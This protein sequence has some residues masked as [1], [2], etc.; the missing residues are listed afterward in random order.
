MEKSLQSK[1][2]LH[3]DTHKLFNN[4]LKIHQAGRLVDAE[5]LYRQILKAEPNHVDALHALGVLAR[6]TGRPDVAVDLIRKAISLKSDAPLFYNNLGTALQDQKKLE[7]ALAQYDHAIA[8]RPDY[9]GAYV[10]I[11]NVYTEQGRLDDAIE[12]YRRAISLNAKFAE[13]Y[14]SLGAALKA[15]NKLDEALI[16]YKQALAIRP[17]YLEACLNIGNVLKE[18]WKLDDAAKYYERAISLSP[19]FAEAHNGLGTVLMA[20]GRLSDAVASYE[21]ALALKPNYA[22]A[23]SNLG[24]ALADQGNLEAA[25][26]QGRLAMGLNSNDADAHY[27]YSITCLVSGNFEEGWR[28]FEW[29]WKRKDVPQHRYNKPLWDG[30]PLNGKTLLLH[31]EQGLGDSIQFIRYA[32]MIDKNGGR[33]VMACPIALMRLF[34][35][36]DGIDGIFPAKQAPPDYDFQA[37]LMSLP[38]LMKTRLETIP[39]SVPYLCAEQE[40]AAAWK[41]RLKDFPG[42]KI[43]VVWRGNPNHKND[44]NRSM[45]PADF[46]AFLEIEGISVVN[47]QKDARD[48]EITALNIMGPFLD[49]APDLQDFADTAALIANLDLVISVDTSVCHLAGALGIPVWTL[50]PHAPDWRWLMTREDSPWYPSMRL[51][52]Q[53]K[54]GDWRSVVKKLGIEIE[55]L[56]HGDRKALLP[57]LPPPQAIPETNRRR[58]TIESHQT[59]VERWSDEKQLEKSWDA[60]AQRAADYVPACA[61]VLDLGCGRMAFEKFLPKDCRYMPCDVARRDERTILCDFNKGEYP[62]AEAGTADIISFLGVMEYIFDARTFLSRLRQWQRPVVMSYCTTEGIRDRNQRRSLG[63]V[64]DFSY[65]ELVR[66]LE[67]TGFSIQ[68]ADRIDSVQ[69]LFRLKPDRAA[70]P[71]IKRVAILSYYN[72]GNFGDRLG[73]H[74]I[75]DILPAHAEA[76]NLTFKPWAPSSETYDLLIL[77]MGNSLFGPMVNDSLLSLV[78]RSRSTIGIFGTQYHEAMPRTMLN[79]LLGRLD[80]WYARYEDDILRYGRSLNNASHLGDWLIK[81]FPMARPVTTERLDIGEEI[82]KELPLDR[83]I[84]NI[85]RHATVFSTRLH[86]LLCALTSA[87]RVGYREQREMKGLTSGKFRSLLL[88]VFGRTFPEE[89]LWAVD[90]AQVLTYKTAIETRVADLRSHIHRILNN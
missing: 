10:N 76:T 4:A 41:R 11:G 79:S 48:N 36:I 7:E 86:P 47:L 16:Q 26:E 69:W 34:K 73:F 74:L 40:S 66:L 18:Q 46:S 24:S 57:P 65:D 60:R 39:A 37:P 51:F 23:R 50:I 89:E 1:N 64:N 56:L 14:N 71:A 35:D 70:I 53:P 87:E 3:Q 2:R 82:L 68:R 85:Q 59:D 28:H 31:C 21:R 77:G 67:E 20:Q 29:R 32:A 52:R 19:N 88:D 8:L 84:Q 61:T 25:A 75:N 63:W 44:H 72:V 12:Q 90:H 17:D 42:L 30:D 6:Q 13:A 15:Q 81:A 49:A 43:G 83:T 78:D 22:E 5:P 54:I 33:I 58:R 55:Q 38:G 9:A 62:D 45:K 27:N 80:H